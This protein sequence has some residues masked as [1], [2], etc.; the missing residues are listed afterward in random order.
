MT[1]LKL[2]GSMLWVSFGVV[3]LTHLEIILRALF[4]ITLL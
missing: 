1:K 3:V 2:I 4:G